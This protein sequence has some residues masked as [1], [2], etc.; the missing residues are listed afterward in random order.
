MMEDVKH[1]GFVPL[2]G[3]GQPFRAQ[4]SGYGFQTDAQ[5]GKHPPRIYATPARAQQ[6]SPVDTCAPVYL[7]E[8]IAK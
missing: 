4:R 8:P 2:L 5:K 7:G 6:Q 3:D 1:I